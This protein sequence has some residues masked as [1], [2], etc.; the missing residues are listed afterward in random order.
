MEY[1]S[2]DPQGGQP[3]MDFQHQ[4]TPEA[5][6]MNVSNPQQPGAN[7]Q[8]NTSALQQQYLQQQLQYQIQIQQMMLVSTCFLS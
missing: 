8:F 1:L 4:Q 7:P 6:Y 5:I 3:Q 2:A